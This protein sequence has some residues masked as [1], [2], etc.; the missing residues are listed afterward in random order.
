MPRKGFSDR[1]PLN[2]PGSAQPKP[3]LTFA[4]AASLG[5]AAPLSM[6]SS[7]IKAASSRGTCRFENR[8]S[9]LEKQIPCSAYQIRKNFTAIFEVILNDSNLV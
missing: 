7:A 1:R 5:A 2:E 9:Y 4:S 8:T 6:L 3:R